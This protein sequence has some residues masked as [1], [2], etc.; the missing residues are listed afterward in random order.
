MP[1]CSPCLC[2]IR[3]AFVSNRVVCRC[4]QA[5]FLLEEVAGL[6]IVQSA[7]K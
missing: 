6:R 5:C 4:K 7:S 1:L 3:M 2:E